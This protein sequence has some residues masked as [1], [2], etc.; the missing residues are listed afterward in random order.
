MERYQPIDVDILKVGHHGS[1]T[2]TSSAFIEWLSPNIALISAAVDNRYGHP[3]DSVLDTLYGRLI[4]STHEVGM[5][6]LVINGDMM[7]VRTKLGVDRQCM[8]KQ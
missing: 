4:L 7:C 2:S 5:V 8:L 1:D 3:H 6:E